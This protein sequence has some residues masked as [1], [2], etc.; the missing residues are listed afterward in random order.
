MSNSTGESCMCKK[1][2]LDVSVNDNTYPSPNKAIQQ[3]KI[4][5]KNKI[6]SKKMR[7]THQKYLAIKN[8]TNN[9]DV[10]NDINHVSSNNISKKQ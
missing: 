1:L 8:V 7:E 2:K 5:L 9:I 6:N 10:S 4:E 3:N